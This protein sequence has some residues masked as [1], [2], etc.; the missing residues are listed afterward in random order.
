[1]DSYLQVI[2]IKEANQVC[3]ELYTRIGYNPERDIFTFALRE[4]VRVKLEKYNA[5]E[6]RD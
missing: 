6:K 2:G 1:M 5:S 4:K 3:A